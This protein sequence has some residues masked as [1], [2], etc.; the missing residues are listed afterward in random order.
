MEE[1]EGLFGVNHWTQM[2]LAARRAYHMADAM[3]AARG[4]QDP[5]IQAAEAAQQNKRGRG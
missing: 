4:K 2:D 5:E 3:I 1:I